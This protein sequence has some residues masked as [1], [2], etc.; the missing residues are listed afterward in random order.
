MPARACFAPGNQSNKTTDAAGLRAI[1]DVSICPRVTG[2][3]RSFALVPRTAKEARYDSLCA[4]GPDLALGEAYTG[5]EMGI[6]LFIV[7]GLIVGLLAR[8]LLPGRQSMGMAMTAVLGMVGS[9]IGGV[10]GNLL[11]SRPVFDLHAAGF[12]GSLVC[13]I[14]LLLALGASGRRRGLV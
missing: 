2:A 12:I 11:A 3:P 14:G 6:L 4:C 10:I 13:S 7:F 9:L 5:G 1:P 8:A